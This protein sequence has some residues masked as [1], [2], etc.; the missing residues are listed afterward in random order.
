MDL[1]S[2]SL[3]AYLEQTCDEEN[4]LLKQINRETYLKETMP[5]MLSGHYQG[6]LLSFLSKLVDPSRILE[7]GTFTGYATLCLAEGLAVNGL[8]HTIEVNEELE[9]RLS[10]YF[11]QSTFSEKIILHIGEA[12]KIIPTLKETFDLVFIDADK[13]N[14]H[15]YYELVLDKVRPGGLILIDN[16]LW[17]GKVLEENPD[18]QT[19]SILTLNEQIASDQRV[20]KIILPIRDGLF[21]IRKR[22]L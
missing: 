13:K 8:I 7:I 14:N 12:L 19:Q 9:P 22:Y 15:N 5:Q 3:T 6:R 18:K 4:D 1:F 16:V 11:Q 21:L 10:N 20:E 17:K 2:K